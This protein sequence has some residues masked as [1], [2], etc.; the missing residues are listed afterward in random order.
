MVLR[1]HW[2]KSL[3]QLKHDCHSGLAYVIVGS[4]YHCKSAKF[5]WPRCIEGYPVRIHLE[6]KY[7]QFM[8]QI[9]TVRI[10]S[11]KEIHSALGTNSSENLLFQVKEIHSAHGTKNNSENSL[12]QVKKIHST[13]GTNNNRENLLFQEKEMH[14]CSIP[15]PSA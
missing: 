13:H 5:S 2:D 11:S 14:C 3:S 7:V 6:R 15:A 12:F 10:H 8:G 1:I 4:E 9:A